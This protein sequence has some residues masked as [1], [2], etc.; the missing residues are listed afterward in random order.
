M[1]SIRTDGRVLAGA[2][3]RLGVGLW[4]TGTGELGDITTGEAVTLARVRPG[5]PEAERLLLFRNPP[6]G[7]A[8]KTVTRASGQARS[9][10]GALLGARPTGGDSR[11]GDG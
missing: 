10:I 5:C 6:T 2:L 3:G 11:R 8:A 7:V 4:D 9:S 1:A